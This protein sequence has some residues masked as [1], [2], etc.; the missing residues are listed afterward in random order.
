MRRQ[1][2]PCCQNFAHGPAR[3]AHELTHAYKLRLRSHAEAQRLEAPHGARNHAPSQLPYY[4]ESRFQQWASKF[5]QLHA[6]ASEHGHAAPPLS[7]PIGRWAD[8]Q[9]LTF[10]RGR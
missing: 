5:N 6:F 9:R 10:H 8:F 4:P 1:C 3:V 2:R 7:L